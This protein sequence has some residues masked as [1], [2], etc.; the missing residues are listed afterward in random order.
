MSI[1]GEN[2]LYIEKLQIG[3]FRAFGAEVEVPLARGINCIAGYNGTGKSTILA[4]LGNCGELKKG[5]GRHINGQQFRGEYS[6]IIKYDDSS[7]TPGVKARLHFKAKDGE[8]IEPPFSLDFRA[9]VQ[10]HQSKV[11]K[12]RESVNDSELY[13]KFQLEQETKRYRLL[14]VK[15][16]DRNTESKITWP[17]YYLG[18]S[19]LYPVGESQHVVQKRAKLED[20]VEREFTE[21]YSQILGIEDPLE[22]TELLRLSDVPKKSGAG[23]RTS[24][25]G[26]LSNSA[27]QDNLAQIL[28]TFLS[29]KQLKEEKGEEYRGG[30]VLIDELE[31]TLHPF[32]QIRLYRKMKMWCKEFDIQ[33]VFTTHSLD[34]LREIYS[35]ETLT[36]KNDFVSVLY[37]TRS[38]GS[39]EVEQNPALSRIEG[40]L[41]AK[42]AG[43]E[44]PIEVP[45]LVEDSVA[46]MVIRKILDKSDRR[47]KL[48]FSGASLGAFE[49]A[50]LCSAYSTFFIDSLVVLDPD[51][52]TV[53]KRTKLKRRFSSQ[54][55]VEG[56]ASSSMG[57]GKRRRVLFLPGTEPIET[58]CWKAISVL[59]SA[60]EFYSSEAA[61]SLGVT[62][63]SL[64][65]EF[66]SRLG[67]GDD[68]L[69]FHKTWFQNLADFG[70]VEM[71]VEQWIDQN[72]EEVANFL[73]CFSN[74][75]DRVLGDRNLV[76]PSSES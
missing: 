4:V 39:L 75:Y 14:P 24:E 68:K 2:R 19:R 45:I 69:E 33:V 55:D 65:D 50:N 29:F 8:H 63:A 30:L 76:P 43:A 52:S 5:Q 62:K 1:Q 7:D 26:P 46:E 32:A 16:P 58:Q 37:L 48:K 11:T 42:L 70:V 56:Q 31:A 71:V 54:F 51:M 15:T 36:K 13:E 9:T 10:T 67:G 59:D 3:N 12:Y 44:E 34:L 22:G 49:I 53:E 66:K 41:R 18:L 74:E 40:D 28:L 38:R 47:F 72:A 20:S 64:V 60:A 57:L 25:Y 21:I 6:D 35:L 73:D 17:V 61:I 23:V 27:G